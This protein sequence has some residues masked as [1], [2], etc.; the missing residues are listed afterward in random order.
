MDTQLCSLTTLLLAKQRCKLMPT[1]T[2]TTTPTLKSNKELQDL[3]LLYQWIK[4]RTSASMS[5]KF[6]H[7]F[8]VLF[9]WENLAIQ[10]FLTF[11]LG[12]KIPLNEIN[13]WFF[14]KHRL[15]FF[16]H[17]WTDQSMSHVSA[18][19]GRQNQQQWTMSGFESGHK[20]HL[21]HVKRRYN[22][23]MYLSKDL[24][25]H[26]LAVIFGALTVVLSNF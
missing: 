8:I 13:F 25:M 14:K 16:G 2:T 22:Q 15:S 3:Q 6:L 9:V 18:F 7:Y 4:R 23:A 19:L 24:K 11:H 17:I 21:S 10:Y 12:A 20:H 1:T 5:L 26:T